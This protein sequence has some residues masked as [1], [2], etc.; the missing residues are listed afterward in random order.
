MAE[1]VHMAELSIYDFDWHPPGWESIDRPDVFAWNWPAWNA[2]SRGVARASFDGSDVHERVREIA[3]FFSARKRSPLWHVGPATRG[4]TLVALLRERAAAVH[5]PRNM[6]AELDKL[7]FR[8]N[9]D[10][11]VE[12]VSSPLVAREWISKCFPD[13]TPE[14]LDIEVDRWVGH[15][16][17]ATRR[18]GDLVAYLA[19]EL[20]G[21]A[22]WRDSSEGD[23]VQFVGGWTDPSLRGRG[24]YST[25]CAYRATA[26]LERGMRYACIIADPT[27]SGPIVRKA[28]FVDHGPHYMFIDVKL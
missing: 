20:A 21:A 19:G 3:D 5:E 10:V 7:R 2:S 18:G 14:M 4:S 16:H 17:A 11:S 26:A 25:L 6:T 1:R 8:S 22:S 15:Q 23:C 28:G 27:T 9:A 24:V 13:L 12:E